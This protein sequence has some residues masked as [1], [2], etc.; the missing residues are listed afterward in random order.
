MFKIVGAEIKKTFSKPGI[1]ILTGILIVVL[2]ACAMFYKPYKKDDVMLTVENYVEG[3]SNVQDVTITKMFE[4]FNSTS[5]DKQNTKNEF[6]GIISNAKSYIDFYYAIYYPEST[7]VTENH[8]F[9]NSE[10][11]VLKSTID[12]QVENV[13]QKWATFIESVTNNPGENTNVARQD[14]KAALNNITTSLVSIGSSELKT[15]LVKTSDY[16]A[17]A[18]YIRQ[19]DKILSTDIDNTTS[20]DGVRTN[21]GDTAFPNNLKQYASKIYEFKPNREVL[22]KAVNYLSNAKEYL[23]SLPTLSDEGN[24]L[25][26]DIYEFSQT[27]GSKTEKTFKTNFN[28]LLTKYKLTAQELKTVCNGLVNVDVLQHYSPNDITKYR[29]LE[30]ENFYRLKEDLTRNEYYLSTKT[31]EFEYA[32]PLNITQASNSQTNAF[33]FAY[34]ALKL[35]AFIII[36]YCVVLAAGSIAGEQQAGTLKLLAIRPY[37]RTKL[38]LG[39]MMATISVGVVL[40]F[41]SAIATLIAGA[42]TYT[43]NSLP[44]LMIFNGTEAIKVNVFFEFIVMLCTMFYELVFFVIMSYGISTIFKSNVGAVA[45][46][47]MIYFV[48]LILNTMSASVSALRFLPFTNMNLFKYFGSSFLSNS[49]GFLFSV[50]TPSVVV[51]ADF[52]FSLLLSGIFAI[53]VL[54]ATLVVFNKRDL[55]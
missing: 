17:F 47:I 49:T 46:S 14:V 51:G 40:L 38:F 20:W 18:Q 9:V 50:L 6:D 4:Y 48:S 26:K 15:V 36:V 2:F 41:L 45:I 5:T 28:K 21:L 33:D 52:V 43:V 1:F 13:K 7:Y 35:C 22:D 44:V 31:F 34:F 19:A 10:N 25:L 30:T 53:V 23:G 37:S 29:T 11:Y 27:N 55:K 16:E 8:I 3:V 32:T 12:A 39:K 24:G 54:I 42:I